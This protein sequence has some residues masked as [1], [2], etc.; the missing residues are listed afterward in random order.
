M[1][2]PQ[3]NAAMRD[4]VKAAQWQSVLAFNNSPQDDQAQS[5]LNAALDQAEAAIAAE[6]ERIIGEDE[7]RWIP[8]DVS[9]DIL[10]DDDRGIR[11]ALRREQRA[12]AANE[13][14]NDETS[15]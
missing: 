8:G 9:G 4:I 7:Q 5:Q 10:D 11:N 15:N 14:G 3:G 12:R 1:T 13:G 6:V 2:H